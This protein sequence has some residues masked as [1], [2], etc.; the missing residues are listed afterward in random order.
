MAFFRRFG[1]IIAGFV[2][3]AFFT[4][5]SWHKLCDKNDSSLLIVAFVGLTLC[6]ALIKELRKNGQNAE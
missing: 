2:F 1:L 5:T 6:I 4:K 3:L